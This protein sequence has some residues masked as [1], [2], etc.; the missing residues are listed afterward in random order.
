MLGCFII[1]YILESRDRKLMKARDCKKFRN[2]GYKNNWIK[3]VMGKIEY[4][5]AAYAIEEN[6]VKN[7][8]IC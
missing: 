7:M 2:K 3:T 4:K 5:R 6:G 1:K 8:Y